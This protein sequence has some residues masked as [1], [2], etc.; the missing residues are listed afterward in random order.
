[1]TKDD[2]IKLYEKNLSGDC[3]PDEKKMLEEYEDDFSLAASPWDPALMGEKEV[4]GDIM[5]AH[6]QAGMKTQGQQARTKRIVLNRIRLAAA[7]I[8]LPL[9]LGGIYLWSRHSPGTENAMAGSLK[10]RFKNDV[11]PGGDK[12]ILTLANGSS[13]ALDSSGKGLL[14]RQGNASVVKTN[15]GQLSYVVDHAV[16]A[17]VTYNTISTPRG[18][19]YE[20]VLPDGSKAWLNAASSL[21]FPTAF[22]GRERRVELTGEGYFEIAKDAARPF[23]VAITAPAGVAGAGA[24]EIEVLGTEFNI[25]AYGDEPSVNTTLVNGSVKLKEA[26]KAWLLKPGQQARLQT[27]GAVD[28]DEAADVDAVTAWK[29]GRFEFSGNIKGIMRQIARWYDVDV[30][31]EGNVS[32]KAFGGTISR[33]A[34]VSEI[35]KVF[36]LTGSIHFRIDGKM[37]TVEP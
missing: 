31:Y 35:L 28:M 24:P 18:G 13:I 30:Q 23:R 17:P 20:V 16:E 8:L 27:D 14:A 29:N 22:T 1:M 34:N 25:M 32:D 10:E 12:A 26:G 7:A 33:T 15:N 3:T 36:E 19:Q 5:Y 11:P 2:F 21:R 9:I 37:I 6:I 4:T